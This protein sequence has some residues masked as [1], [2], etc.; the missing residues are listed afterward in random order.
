MVKSFIQDVFMNFIQTWEKGQGAKEISHSFDVAIQSRCQDM[1]IK[2][3]SFGV[4]GAIFKSDGVVAN[5]KILDFDFLLNLLCF[6][7]ITR[8]VRSARK[9]DANS[10]FQ[11]LRQ[12][13][14]NQEPNRN[15][16]I[17]E[18]RA[19]NKKEVSFDSDSDANVKMVKI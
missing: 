10:A 14:S 7:I 19:I 16:D 4:V 8:L 17:A 6:V 5:E 9:K 13:F 3:I 1:S 18:N 12:G 2:S 15:L 11:K